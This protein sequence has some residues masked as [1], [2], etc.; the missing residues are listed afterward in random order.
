MNTLGASFYP[1]GVN[2]GYRKQRTAEELPGDNADPDSEFI[3][4]PGFCRDHLERSRLNRVR[5]G[6]Q[7]GGRKCSQQQK[8][9]N[10]DRFPK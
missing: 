6:T 9:R 1:P 10:L 8:T 3:V 2:F 7:K 4:K 5:Q